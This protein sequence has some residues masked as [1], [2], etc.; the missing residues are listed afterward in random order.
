MPQNY[1]RRS[2]KHWSQKVLEDALVERPEQNTPLRKLA[3][4]CNIPKSSLAKH[5]KAVAIG[6]D[7]TG[8]VYKPVFNEDETANLRECIV[9]LASLGFG[10]R[11]K[12]LQN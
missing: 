6:K 8:Q 1:T 12:I 9:Q 7:L 11:R 3:K 5:I 2:T 10:M 4:K